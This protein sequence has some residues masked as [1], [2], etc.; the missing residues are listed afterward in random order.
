[1]AQKQLQ[2]FRVASLENVVNPVA[3][4]IYFNL[5]DKTINVRTD[6][7]WDKFAGNLKDI[8]WDAAKKI[9]TI[10][11]YDDSTISLN[12]SDIASASEV[13]AQLKTIGEQI[14]ALEKNLGDTVADLDAEVTSTDGT[15]VAVKVTEVDGVITAVNVSESDIASAEALAQEVTDRQQA[16]TGL[17][18][19]AAEDYNTLGKLED[20]IQAVVADAKS[21]SIVAVTE[22]LS[23]NVKEAFKLV[24][25]DGTQAGAQINVYKDS[26]LQKVE[27]VGQELQFTYLLASGEEETVGVDVSAFLA[28]SEFADG[29][30]VVDHIVKVKIDSTS[31]SFLTVDKDGVKLAGVQDAI[32]TAVADAAADIKEVTDDLNE[33]VI[34]LEAT[35]ETVASALQAKDI[36]T[37]SAN[38]T[39][40]VKGEDIAV[41]GL[42]SA[43][44][45]EASAY[46][47]ADQGA[48]ADSAVQSVVTGSTAGTIAVDGTDVAVN[49]LKSAAF[50]E[51]TA[52]DAAG[53]AANAQAA[54]IEEA[55]KLA[56]AAQAA[57][58]TKVVEGTDAG[59]NIEIVS[60]TDE[61]GAVTYTVNLTDVASAAALAKEA[62]DRADAID[63]IN[64]KIGT[65]TEGKDVVTMISDAEAAA[66]AYADGLV[67]NEDGTA[68][69]DA[70][71]AAATAEQ[72]AKDYADGLAGN[73][74]EAGAAAQALAD[75]KS[76]ADGLWMWGEF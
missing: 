40:A 15:H 16:I 8:E 75:A 42:G 76:Y 6:S 39:I 44:Y 32:D 72:N 20:K 59:N 74:D 21:Y 53:S 57:A 48:L 49:G 22:G 19:D 50:V 2:F 67:K 31:E 69:F 46:A 43:A 58:T 34:E 70:A 27:L 45:T 33:R 62:E 13:A 24:D 35:K 73:Y 63:A 4:G 5:A 51:T 14:A 30:Q 41:K 11:K 65:V 25:E 3:G 36:E 17:L 38:G 9:L 12:L 66:K 7:G 28:E 52:F 10:N 29:L 68:K 71:G 64:E 23:A 60:A 1:M 56:N 37:G 47:T 26:A 54:A 55:R 18:G 61:A